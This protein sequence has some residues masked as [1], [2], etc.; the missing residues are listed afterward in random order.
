M[1]WEKRWWQ[2]IGL[3]ATLVEKAPSQTLGRTAIV[4]LPF[5]LQVLR[6]VP[7]GYDFRLYTYG[8]FDCDVLEDLSYARIAGAVTEKVVLH[9]KGYG[10]EV[11]PGARKDKLPDPAK[12]WLGQYEEAIDWVIREFGHCTA[13]ELELVSTIIF[14]DRENAK[15]G[16][17]HTLEGLARQVRE[18]KPRFPL[19]YVL[20][21]CRDAFAKSFLLS[22]S[23]EAGR[24]SE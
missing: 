12:E 23:E 1:N 7:L 15:E 6:G 10:Y 17:P 3:I 22:G 4:K 24:K 11:K 2:R 8:P 14:V 16:V 13:S 18:V 9:P 20:A 19:A 21:K 5:L